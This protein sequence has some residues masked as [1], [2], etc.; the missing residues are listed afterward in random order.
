MKLGPVSWAIVTLVFTLVPG[1]ADAQSAS[2][3]FN[4]QAKQRIAQARLDLSAASARMVFSLDA[5][6]SGL[7]ADNFGTPLVDTLLDDSLE[8]G[9]SVVKTWTDVGEAIAQD[10]TD[11]LE[12]LAFTGPLNGNYPDDFLVGAGGA[13]DKAV[14]KLEKEVLRAVKTVQ[15]RAAKVEAAAR[16]AG[17]GVSLKV[18][19]PKERSFSVPQEKGQFADSGN[20]VPVDVY[21]VGGASQLDAAEDALIFGAGGTVD[22]FLN[23]LLFEAVSRDGAGNTIFDLVNVAPIGDVVPG[24]DGWKAILDGDGTGLREGNWNIR[25]GD[26]SF[27]PGVAR[28]GVR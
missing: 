8:F 18:F 6:L 5:F 11:A 27:G 4:R 15:T 3:D 19:V 20:N 16:V 14:A 13:F 12:T 7:Q 26:P 28:L 1:E 25:A 17:F 22:F 21:L 10:G 2:A 9:S 23:E 24:F